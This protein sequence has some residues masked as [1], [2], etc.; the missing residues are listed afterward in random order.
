MGSKMID[1]NF[2]SLVDNPGK[3]V[4]LLAFFLK[5]KALSIDFNPAPILF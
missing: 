4:I 5:P 1:T 2:E 3:Y